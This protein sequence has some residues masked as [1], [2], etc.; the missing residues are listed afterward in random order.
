[1]EIINK[2]YPEYGYNVEYRLIK[3]LLRSEKNKPGLDIEWTVRNEDGDYLMNGL[4]KSNDYYRS[5]FN[6]PVSNMEENIYEILFYLYF[7]NIK[8]ECIALVEDED[9]KGW[10]KGDEDYNE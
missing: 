3:D 5:T 1:M 10:E 4:F 7:E 2:S 9:T 8:L 6:L